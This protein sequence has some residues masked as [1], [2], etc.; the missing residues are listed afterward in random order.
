M[1]T[2]VESAHRS[3]EGGISGIRI[4]DSDVR[5]RATEHSE[6]PLGVEG[7]KVGPDKYDESK[8]VGELAARSV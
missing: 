4:F 1:N 2:A 3:P 5:R 6:V 8:L 7:D